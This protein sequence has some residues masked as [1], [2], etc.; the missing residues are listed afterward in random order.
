[1]R[2]QEEYIKRHN[3][4][5]KPIY[6]VKNANIILKSQPHVIINIRLEDESGRPAH[7]IVSHLRPN[8]KGY[9][10]GNYFL[11]FKEN[12]YQY[13]EYTSFITKC[14]KTC[15]FPL[16][17]G[18]IKL[19]LW[20]MFLYCFDGWIVDE[21]LKNFAEEATQ[22]SCPI[23][24]RTE[25]VSSF[26]NHLQMQHPLIWSIYNDEFRK[27]EIDYAEWLVDLIDF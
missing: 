8:H 1:M 11:K 5:Y 7:Y 23:D 26:L 14:T 15:E 13:E 12:F 3:L 19:A 25:A 9:L 24:K 4:K 6:H 16:K 10:N 27:Y 17:F 18:Q 21:I 2:L 22:P 20:E